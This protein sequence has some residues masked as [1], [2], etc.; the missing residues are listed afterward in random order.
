ME[1]CTNPEMKTEARKTAKARLAAIP[2]ET[3]TAAG[4]AAARRLPL[5]PRWGSFRSVLA[6]FSMKDEIDTRPVMETVLAAG[7]SLFAPRIEGEALVFYRIDRG[8][9]AGH[10]GY[11]EPKAN[12]ALALMPEDFPVLVLCP[13]LA[14]DRHLN[15]L[16]RGRGYYDRFFASL[17]SAGRHYTPLGLCMDCQLAGQ[18]PAGPE[19]RRMEALLTE[20]GIF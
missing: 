15:R 6:F 18:V 2:P 16:G 14:F 8:S 1:T 4:A 12:P 7:K 11:R 9:L 10:R 5:I 19:D 20:S 3:F 17:D 13:G